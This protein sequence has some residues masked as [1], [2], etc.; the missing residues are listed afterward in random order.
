MRETRSGLSSQLQLWKSVPKTQLKKKMGGGSHEENR[1]LKFLS[2]RGQMAH[3]EKSFNSMCRA[4][5][6]STC[7]YRK[8]SSVPFRD[9]ASGFAEGGTTPAVCLSHHYSQKV[10]ATT[11]CLLEHLHRL[12]VLILRK[13]LHHHH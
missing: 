7:I 2:I 5:V 4:D 13:P 8:R 11:R 6:S 1:A 9:T 3:Q 10:M 12:L